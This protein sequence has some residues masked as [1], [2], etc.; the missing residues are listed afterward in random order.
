MLYTKNY[1]IY[2]ELLCDHYVIQKYLISNIEYYEYNLSH[3][4]Q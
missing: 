3:A 2:E 1:A 4:T